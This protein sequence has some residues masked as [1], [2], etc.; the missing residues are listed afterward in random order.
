MIKEIQK[1]EII[2]RIYNEAKAKELSK[3]ARA[4]AGKKKERIKGI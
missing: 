3:L 4:T 2:D 1:S